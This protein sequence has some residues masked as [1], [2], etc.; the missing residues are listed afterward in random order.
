M[1]QVLRGFLVPTY[2]PILVLITSTENVQPRIKTIA[3]LLAG[4]LFP[5]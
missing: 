5:S 2:H 4:L 3:D 1:K